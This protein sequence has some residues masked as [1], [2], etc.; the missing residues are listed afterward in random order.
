[1]TPVKLTSY[2]IIKSLPLHRYI[3]LIVNDKLDVYYTEE[4]RGNHVIWRIPVIDENGMY[5]KRLKVVKVIFTPDNVSGAITRSLYIGH[6][7][8][9]N[10]LSD[11]YP[12][13]FI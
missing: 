3:L 7:A 6:V 13:Y 4:C 2:D 5:T 10:K 1:M 11:E 8:D 9:P 12:E